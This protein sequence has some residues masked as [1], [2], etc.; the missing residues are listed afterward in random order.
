MTRYLE[1]KVNVSEYSGHKAP[2]SHSFNMQSLHE[3][4]KVNSVSGK[5][6]DQHVT[7]KQT[8]NS[9]KKRWEPKKIRKLKTQTQSPTHSVP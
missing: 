2:T 1:N 8:V 4:M 9:L 5:E 7:L 3:Y 6:C